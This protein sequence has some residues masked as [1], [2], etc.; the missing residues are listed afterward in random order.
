MKTLIIYDSSFGNTKDI[1]E[2]IYKGVSG[3][4]RIVHVSEFKEGDLKDVTFL[5]VGSPIQG[6][7]PTESTNRWLGSLSSEI[8][9]GVKVTSFD[10]RMKIFFHGDAAEKILSRL[11]DKGGEKLTEPKIFFVK[12]KEG[13]L[14]EGE[15]ERATEW[16][17]EIV[18]SS[19]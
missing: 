7:R 11:I 12:G 6:W 15:I 1:A 3:D 19:E 13:P 14:L 18:V 4:K 5:I 2:A 10:T 17:K 16:G 9:E 8:L